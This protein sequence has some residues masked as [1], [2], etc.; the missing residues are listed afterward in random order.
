MFLRWTCGGA[1]QGRREGARRHSVRGLLCSRGPLLQGQTGRV[2]QLWLP[3][4]SGAASAAAR[5]WIMSSVSL[6]ELKSGGA[7]G[8]CTRVRSRAPCIDCCRCAPREAPPPC[9]SA[10]PDRLSFAPLSS[11]LGL[12]PAAPNVYRAAGVGPHVYVSGEELEPWRVVVFWR[13]VVEHA[14]AEAVELALPAGRVWRTRNVFNSY[15][16]IRIT[17]T[18]PPCRQ[19]HAPPQRVATGVAPGCGPPYIYIYICI[20]AYT[21]TYA[22][23]HIHIHMRAGSGG[24]ACGSRSGSAKWRRRP[25]P[26]L[27]APLGGGAHLL[28]G[29]QVMWMASGV[30]FMRV[31]SCGMK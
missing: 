6:H 29:T 7:S 14:V 19:P 26:G 3:S 9:S 17:G 5:A 20:Y 18:C 1:T 2:R 12:A 10:R 28:S 31:C 27:R 8:A 13:V 21:Y 30:T 4:C 15:N 24:T 25:D 16:T 22:Y 23:T 11:S